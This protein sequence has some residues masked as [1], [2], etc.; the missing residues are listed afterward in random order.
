MQSLRILLYQ[1]Y[2]PLFLWNCLFSI[3]G[4]YFLMING[5]GFLLVSISLKLAGYGSTMAYQHMFSLKEHYYYRN[6]GYAMRKIYSYSFAA[7]LLFY[8]VIVYLYTVTQP[9]FYA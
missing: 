9:Y 5:I 7:D 3:A 2:K 6:A 8:L 4:V 1:F